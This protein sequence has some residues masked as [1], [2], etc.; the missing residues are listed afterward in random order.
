MLLVYQIYPSDAMIYATKPFR[1]KKLYGV[2]CVK[3][4][5]S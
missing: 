1:N 3:D 2:G 4:M 5:I